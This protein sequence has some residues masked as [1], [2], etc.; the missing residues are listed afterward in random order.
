L[1]AP[2]PIG[3]T[4]PPMAANA[5]RTSG[6]SKAAKVAFGVISRTGTPPGY[7]ADHHRAVLARD[8]LIGGTRVRPQ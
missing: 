3:V 1:K 5:A 8:L 7:L 6:S 4:R 2:A